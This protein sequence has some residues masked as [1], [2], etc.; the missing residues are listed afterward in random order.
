MDQLARRE[1]RV[2]RHKRL[3][4][5]L[6]H[7][8]MPAGRNCYLRALLDLRPAVAPPQG[9]LRQRRVH[10]Q[11]RHPL[12]NA[13]DPVSS[14]RH[15]P[16]QGAKELLLQRQP[17]LVRVEDQRLVLLQLRCDVALGVGQ[18][19]LADVRLRHL[20][21]VRVRDLY[22]VA[23]DLVVAHLQALDP[24]PPSLDLLE[25]GD[26]ILGVPAVLDDRVQ[27]FAVARPDNARLR[28]RGR[29]LVFDRPL[30]QVQLRESVR[31]PRQHLLEERGIALPLQSA[32]LRGQQEVAQ[33]RRPPQRL[34]HAHQV[35][36]RRLALR[37]A[38]DPPLQVPHAAQRI[39]RLRPQ[40]SLLQHRLHRV[41]PF[42]DAGDVQQRAAQP[43][44]QQPPSHRRQCPVEHAQ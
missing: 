43:P 21:R 11:L 40:V 27:L 4:K 23:E 30:Q 29:G 20:V 28:Q 36:R 1:T 3:V 42:V 37:N 31:Q 12:G 41:Q 19:L 33:A 9:D 38:V 13:A 8:R 34:A 16:A 7:N 44:A 17:P 35:A 24:Q 18:R 15:L 25:R 14:R 22:V 26:P 32:L 10:V 39:A 6:L 5:R 2:V